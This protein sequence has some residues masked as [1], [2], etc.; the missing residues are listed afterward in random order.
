[1]PRNPTYFPNGPEPS[2]SSLPT[3]LINWLDCQSKHSKDCAR[4]HSHFTTTVY[5][6]QQSL[7]RRTITQHASPFLAFLNGHFVHTLYVLYCTV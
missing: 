5:L 6:V 2:T 4:L 1:M 3:V 7:M